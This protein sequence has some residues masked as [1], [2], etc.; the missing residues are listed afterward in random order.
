MLTLSL[1]QNAPA[2]SS[3]TIL[4]ATGGSPPTLWSSKGVG[5]W[6]LCRL[7]THGFGLCGALMIAHGGSYGWS[8]LFD[9][10]GG[11]KVLAPTCLG[12]RIMVLGCRG[13]QR[14]V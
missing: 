2:I 10:L 7:P 4:I 6:V 9:L 13:V 14:K 12:C 3:L 8:S 11:Q 5:V 1:S